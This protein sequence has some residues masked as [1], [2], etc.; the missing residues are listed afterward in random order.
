LLKKRGPDPEETRSL[1]IVFANSRFRT[2]PLSARE[3]ELMREHAHL[4]AMVSF[5]RK[6]VAEHF[7]ANRH[8][9]SPAVAVK[10]FNATA[11]I[12]ER[13]I[14]HL[15]AASGALSQGRTGL[16]RCAVRAV[17]LGWH[18]QVRCC[19][20]DP[21]SADIVD[22][23]EDRRNR[24]GLAGRFGSPGGRVKIFDKNLIYAI[25]GGKGLDCGPA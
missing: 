23:G 20:P 13:L 15:H 2:L 12:A 19:Q 17:E 16:L 1:S 3:S 11:T 14:E 4:P 18:V 10:I 6:H 8:R 22:V 5:V 9:P 24:A 7:Q 25:V 21:L